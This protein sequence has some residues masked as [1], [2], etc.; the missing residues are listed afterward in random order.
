MWGFF[1]GGIMDWYP[2][3]YKKFREKT[4]HLTAEQDGIYRRLIDYYMEIRKPLPSDDISLARISG[5][6]VSCFKQASSTLKAFFTEE[7]GTLK[8][9]TCDEMLDEQDRV[10]KFRTERARKGAEARHKKTAENKVIPASSKQEAMLNPATITETDNKV[11]K[12]TTPLPP[13]GGLPE[14][15]LMR[16]GSFKSPDMIFEECWKIYPQIRSKGDKSKAKEQFLKKM[17]EG[18]D[19]ETIKRGIE[20]YRRYCDS[21]GEKQ[22]DMFRWVRDN[23]WEREYPKAQTPNRNNQQPYGNAKQSYSDTL[24]DSVQAAKEI[25]RVG[26]GGIRSHAEGRSHNPAGYD[27][28]GGKISFGGFHASQPADGNRLAIPT[29]QPQAYALGFGEPDDE[30]R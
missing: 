13:K 12:V 27:G 18:K 7:E 3:H 2:W 14:S 9:K 25:V 10:A 30:N 26:E 6:D 4:L 20:E 1:Y 11:T 28:I 5:V 23:G 15:I 22:P 17:K 29:R 16:D 8:H 21:T 24:R 19:H